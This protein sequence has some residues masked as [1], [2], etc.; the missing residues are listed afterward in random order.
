MALLTDKSGANRIVAANSGF[1]T[2]PDLEKEL[3]FG[4]K[5]V[6]LNDDDLAQSFRNNLIILLGELDNENEKGGTLLRSKTVDI[7]GIHRYER[8]NYFYE[9]SKNK[10]KDLNAQFNW[11]I[12]SVPQTGHNYELMGNA[13]ANLLYE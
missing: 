3:P 4:M 1:Y 8:G 9:Y 2:L 10:A 6:G 7:Q 12:V 5:D 11:Q 13:A